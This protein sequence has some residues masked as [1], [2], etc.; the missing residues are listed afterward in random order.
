MHTTMDTIFTAAAVGLMAGLSVTTF[1]R[2]DAGNPT[3]GWSNGAYQRGFEERFERSIP[4]HSGSVALWAAARWAL[5]EEPATGALAG[6]DGW[7]FTQDEFIEP[8]KPRDF[9][10]ELTRVSDS[11]KG[12][13]IELVPVVVPDKARMQAHRLPRGRSQSFEIRY[14]T[15]LETI[16]SAGLPVID[17]RLALDFDASYMRTDT[18]WSP[19]GARRVAALIAECLAD[20]DLPKVDVETAA[21]GTRSLDGD[22]LSFVATG[23]FRDRVGPL[24][25][26][27]ETF[28]TTVA[29][30]GALFGDVVVPVA[31]VGTSFS[32]KS[33]FHFEGFLKQALQADVLNV[34]IIGQGPFT[35][36]DSFL[37]ELSEI[38]SP[39]SL[40]V[41]EIPERFLTTRSPLK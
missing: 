31:L 15:A 20:F 37:A 14:E 23:A 12:Q 35:P 16:N 27:I 29:T 1:S 36:M 3:S 17:L 39:P 24:D 2:T 8:A 11:L 32:A 38:S 5:F 18:H 25:E 10:R 28:E 7:L 26:T 13:G 41:W 40:V 34:S 30:P 9:A 4:S 22:L 6:Q 19:E 21:T 33:D